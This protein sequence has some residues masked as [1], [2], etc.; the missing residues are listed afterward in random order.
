MTINLTPIIQAIIGLLGAIITYYLIPWL[1][2]NLSASK[3]QMLQAVIRSLVYAAEQLYGSGKGEEK[4][5][6]VQEQ[7]AMRC[8][9]IDRTAIE[10]AVGEMN[11]GGIEIESVVDI[12]DD[13]KPKE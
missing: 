3:Y 1:K 4:L 9:E 10:A 6:W 11:F 8:Y 2:Q 7:L 12:P 5:R 13:E